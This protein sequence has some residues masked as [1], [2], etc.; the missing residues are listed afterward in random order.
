MVPSSLPFCFLP[1]SRIYISVFGTLIKSEGTNV[2]VYFCVLFHATNFFV[3]VFVGSRFSG[4]Q[5]TA[6]WSALDY[7]QSP[8]E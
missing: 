1:F 5:G 2:I 3:L 4:L 6:L 7:R 8:L